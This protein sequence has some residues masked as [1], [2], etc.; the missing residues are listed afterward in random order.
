M[1]ARGKQ[2]LQVVLTLMAYSLSLSE[3]L[4]ES[5]YVKKSRN[6]HLFLS[7][8]ESPVAVFTNQAIQSR[9]DLNTEAPWVTPYNCLCF[10]LSGS[11]LTPCTARLVT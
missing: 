5:F 3:I 9:H 8:K 10:I 1:N 2:L 6:M 4:L 7:N 11:A